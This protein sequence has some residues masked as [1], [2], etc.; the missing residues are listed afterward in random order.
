MGSAQKS[1][2]AW[3]SNYWPLLMMMTWKGPNRQMINFPKKFL[4]LPSVMCANGFAS[5]HLVK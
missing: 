3:L 4:T 2:N 1:L 5:T